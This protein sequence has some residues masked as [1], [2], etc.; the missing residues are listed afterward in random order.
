VGENL[1][2]WPDGLVDRLQGND[3]REL[4][5]GAV[6]EMQTPGGGGWGRP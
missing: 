2:H 4:P 3:E 5:E 1:V 6:F